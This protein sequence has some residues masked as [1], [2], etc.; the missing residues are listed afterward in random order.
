MK[1][2]IIFVAL[3]GGAYAAY[4][5]AYPTYSYR[6]RITIEV[7]TA[8]GVKAGSSVLETKTIQYPRWVTLG[9][10]DHQTT[11]RGEAVFVELG[12]GRNLVALLA[13][14]PHAED[15]RAALFAP[16]SFFSIVEGVPHDIEWTK[17]LST[18]SGRRPYAGDRRPTL[19]TFADPNNPASV[20]EVPFEDPQSVLAPDVQSVRAWIDLTKDPVTENLKTKLPWIDQFASA[21]IAWRIVRRGQYGSSSAPLQVFKLRS[22]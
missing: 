8:D 15:G 14:R 10:N 19:V 9:A 20:R 3:L 18:M 1:W 2:V 7:D 17:Q 22:E 5:I 4:A 21:E 11:V 13:L 6:Y 12:G 16:R